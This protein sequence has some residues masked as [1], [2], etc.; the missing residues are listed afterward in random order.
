MV[1]KKAEMCRS[2]RC[3]DREY[4]TINLLMKTQVHG[5]VFL[6]TST[7]WEIFNPKR[8]LIVL[9]ECWMGLTQRW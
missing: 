1:K 8:T 2:N 5:Y 9:L 4:K 3:Q 6:T 7:S